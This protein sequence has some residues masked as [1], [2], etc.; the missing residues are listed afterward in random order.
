MKHPFE[1]GI[2]LLHENRFITPKAQI[3]IFQQ[4]CRKSAKIPFSAGIRTRSN[5]NIQAIFRC[6]AAISR[7]VEASPKSELPLMRLMEVPAHYRFYA[8]EARSP[9]FC[10]AVSPIGAWNSKVV[11]R[12]GK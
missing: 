11:H 6:G 8:V 10:K 3:V 2:D 4:P 7:N 12:A 1:I 9:H 5:D